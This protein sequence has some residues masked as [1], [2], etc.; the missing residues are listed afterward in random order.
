VIAIMAMTH[1]ELTLTY[2]IMWHI[3]STG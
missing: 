3:S 2:Y 1:A